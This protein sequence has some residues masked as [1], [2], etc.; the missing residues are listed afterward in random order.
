MF[1][2]KGFRCGVYASGGW[3]KNVVGPWR[4]GTASEVDADPSARIDCSFGVLFARL[5]GEHSA[6]E[7]HDLEDAWPGVGDH[8]IGGG[9]IW[10][11]GHGT[12]RAVEYIDGHVEGIGPVAD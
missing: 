12:G 5:E 11:V 8:L 2:K 3:N 9:S 7:R 6:S 4:A 10:T 1:A